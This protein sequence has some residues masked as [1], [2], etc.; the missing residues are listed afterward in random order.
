VKEDTI[1][2]PAIPVK[3]HLAVTLR[4]ELFCTF[5]FSID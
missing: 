2:R 3:A 4:W 1:M 5:A